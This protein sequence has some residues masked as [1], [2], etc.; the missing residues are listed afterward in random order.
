MISLDDGSGGKAMY[1]LI[2]KIRSKLNGVSGKFKSN[3]NNYV[4]YVWENTDDDGATINLTK[5]GKF[6]VFTTDSYTVSPIFF[7]G[8]D[9]GKLSFCGTVNDLSVMNAIPVGISLSLIIEEGFERENLMKIVSSIG[10]ISKGTKTPIV[11][12]DTKVVGRGKIDKIMINT[13]GIGITDRI[14]SNSGLKVGDK[15]IISGGIGEHGIA[16]LS[17]RFDYKTNLVSDC[18]PLFEQV[19]KISSYVTAMKDPTRGGIASALNEMAEKSKVRIILNED[20][21]PIKKEVKAVCELLGLN[22][23]EIASEGRFVC[24][25]KAEYVE[26][27]LKIL[28]NFN[29]DASIIGDIIKG[30]GVIIKTTVGGTRTLDVPSGKLVP[31]IC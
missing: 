5:D 4:N 23:Y 22:P 14:I 16:L 2:K 29:D 10:K 17:K 30:K 7:P 24:G 18:C 15:I 9:I 19:R 3:N 20:K 1:E 28:R 25:V 12:G 8:G 26:D 31:R 27:V 13:S 21:I 6:V 11:T